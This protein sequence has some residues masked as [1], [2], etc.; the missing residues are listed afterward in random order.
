MV[1]SKKEI[2]IAIIIGLATGAFFSYFIFSPVKK[3]NTTYPEKAKPTKIY[4][5][6]T[7]YHE[8]EEV[9]YLMVETPNNENFTL[10]QKVN[11][12]GKAPKESII[13]VIGENNQKVINTKDRETFNTELD[14]VEGEN[15]IDII[16]ILKN[17]QEQYQSLVVV[18]P[19]E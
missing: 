14:L 12:S 17:G 11:I 5:S 7:N 4:S 13:F 15:Q 18:Y 10:N 8:H 19:K 9:K 3:T 16:S 1:G 2:I 6:P